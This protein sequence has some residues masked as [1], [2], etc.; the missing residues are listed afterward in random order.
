MKQAN[1]R[2]IAIIAHVDH[3]KTTLVDAMLKQTKTFADHQK[4]NQQTTILD[5]NDLERE[6]GVTILAKNTAVFWHD[7]K[8]NIL[9]TP[10]HADFS[11]EV[12]RVLNMADGCVLLVDAA[13]GVLSQ[14]RFVLS[15]ALRLGLR[16]IVVLNKID[17]K[18]QRADEVIEEIGDLFL[19]VATDDDQLNFP[20]IYAQGIAGIAGKDV[21]ENPDH[22]LK[23]TDS[24]DLTPLFELLVRK[25]P[26]PEG[27]ATQPLQVQIN[28]LDA[29]NHLGS[30]VVGRVFRGTIHKNDP[31][32]VVDSDGNLIKQA[33]VEHLFVHQGLGRQAVEEAS[34]GEIIALSG[35][36]EPI[37][38]QTITSLED[39]TPLPQL[40]ISE[41]TVQMLMS[42]NTSPFVGKEAEFSTSRQLN[43][44]LQRELQ[45]N[46]GL[47]VLPGTTGESMLLV[48]RGE[49]HLAIL[50]ETM[51]REGYE[52]SLSRPQVVFKEIDGVKHE[53]WESVT[54]DVPEEHT[55]Y[56][57]SSMAQRKA[58]LINMRS[59]KTS[60]RFEYEIATANLIGYRRELISATSGTGVINSL[61]L[62]YRPVGEIA[63][64]HRGGAIIAQ[65]NGQTTAYALEKSQQRG[66][67][68]VNPGEDVYG[69]QVVGINSRSQDMAMNVCK[70]KKL[71][72]MRTSSS[73]GTVILA[74]AWKPSLEQFITIIGPDEMLEVTPQN[75]RLRKKDLT[76]VNK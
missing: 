62:E 46:V 57:T 14:T 34:A 75:L 17:R 32:A 68:M 3:G 61:F 43:T 42:V 48:G 72:N 36:S 70:G 40:A 16:P 2:N 44:R 20:I 60:M 66:K 31:I 1:L 63:E 26:A 59:T 28:S 24:D 54:I 39:Q 30:I 29:D 71:T 9:D 74:P 67:M 10:G 21:E 65:L 18:D 6:R 22:S 50:V 51:R 55:G 33:R 11:G 25:V 47:K 64:W 23:V 4:E 38:G 69:G 35:V 76:V 8:I 37:I 15:L 56:V 73:D 53:P 52:F 5:S 27:D 49:L 41:P 12:E 58:N 45:T 13:E 7:Y 19:D